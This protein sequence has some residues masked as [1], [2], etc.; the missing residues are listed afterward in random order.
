MF[1]S[2]ISDVCVMCMMASMQDMQNKMAYLFFHMSYA[3]IF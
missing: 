1:L 3:E 2:G